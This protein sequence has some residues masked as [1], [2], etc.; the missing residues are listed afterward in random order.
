[1]PARPY[2]SERHQRNN[3][4]V[5]LHALERSPHHFAKMLARATA[6]ERRIIAARLRNAG[7]TPAQIASAGLEVQP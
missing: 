4:L 3:D 7:A 6:E 2:D 5:L 1:M